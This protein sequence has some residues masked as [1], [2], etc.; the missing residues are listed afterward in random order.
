MLQAEDITIR[1]GGRAIVERVDL[2]VAPGECLAV[3]GRNGAGKTT[4]IRGLAG[5]LKLQ[6]RVTLDGSALDR[7]SPAER[8]RRVGYV[9]QGVAQLSAQLTVFDLL[10]LA[11]NGNRVGWQVP[12]SDLARAEAMLNLLGLTALAGRMPAE[13]S[14]GQRQ[15]VSLA[16]AL[17]REPRLLLLDEPTSA[18]DLANQLQ[19]LDIIRDYTRREG[20]VTLMVLHDLNLAT[21]YSDRVVMLEAGRLRYAGTT[22]DAFTQARLAEIYHVDCHIL[23]LESGHTAIYPLAATL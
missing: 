8:T 11:R 22:K 16:L 13:L 9:A 15:M 5:L 14:G 7:L 19:L 3:L 21:R 1:I 23:P 18:L 2:E 6:G 20:I 4:L 17:V 12:R 10:L